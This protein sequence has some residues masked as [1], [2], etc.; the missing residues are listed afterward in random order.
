M[1]SPKEHNT[2][3]IDVLGVDAPLAYTPDGA[4]R[5]QRNDSVDATVVDHELGQ[6][7]SD[8]EEVDF[9]DVDLDY[10]ATLRPSRLRGKKLL[11]MITYVCGTAFVCFGFDQG[12]LSSLLTLP[13][14]IEV[15]PETASGFGSAQSLLVA[16]CKCDGTQGTAKVLTVRPSGVLLRSSLEHLR[17]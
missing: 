15:F 14:F 17:R 13:A 4:I 9:P 12:V 3:P 5:D 8:K 10:A 6:V 2:G 16:I 11:Y 1:S 7:S